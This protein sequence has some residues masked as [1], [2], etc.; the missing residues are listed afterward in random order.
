MTTNKM[1][2]AYLSNTNEPCPHKDLQDTW[3]DDYIIS[4][5]KNLLGVMVKTTTAVCTKCESLVMIE[6]DKKYLR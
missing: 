5:S 3:L 2:T 4:K 6:T 1:P